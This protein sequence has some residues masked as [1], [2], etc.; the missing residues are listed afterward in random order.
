MQ[1]NKENTFLSYIIKEFKRDET[2]ASC[3]RHLAELLVLLLW[4]MCYSLILHNVGFSW[5]ISVQLGLIL[6]VPTTF[7]SNIAVFL[8]DIKECIEENNKLLKKKL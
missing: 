6:S 8:K 3:G 5:R 1:K 7:L 2:K 4:L